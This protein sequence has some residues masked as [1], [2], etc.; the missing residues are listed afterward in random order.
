MWIL[1]MTSKS[2][3]LGWNRRKVSYPFSHVDVSMAQQDNL[4]A[5]LQC[6]P[7]LLLVCN[8]PPG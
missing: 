4:A 3:P 7:D 1:P 5:L 6:R 2:A 8:G